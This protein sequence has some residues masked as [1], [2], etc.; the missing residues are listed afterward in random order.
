MLAAAYHGALALTVVASIGLAVLLATTGRGVAGG[1]A[2]AV[3]VALVAVWVIGLETTPVLLAVA[4]LGGAAFLRFALTFGGWPQR[5]TVTTGTLLGAG[6]ASAAGLAA[7][8][9]T[10]LDGDIAAYR[11]GPGGWLVIAVT[12]GLAGLGHG[13]LAVAWHRA[14]GLRRRQL[15]AVLLSGLWGLGSLSSLVLPTLGLPPAPVTVPLLPLYTVGLVYGILRYRLMEVNVWAR[16][17]LAWGL[18]MAA[19]G[20]LVGVVAVVPPPLIDEAP[21]LT[22]VLAAVVALALGE[23]AR[24]LADRLVYPGAAITPHPLVLWRRQLAA[25]VDRPAR[26]LRGA[27]ELGR[28]LGLAVAVTWEHAA[29]GPALVLERDGG[30]AW[31]CRLTGWDEAP[32]GPLLVAHSFAATLAEAA[33]RLDLALSLAARE[34]ERQQQERLAELGALAATVAHDLRNPLNIVAMAVA[35]ADPAIRREVAE[36]IGRMDWLVRDLLDYARPWDI[37]ARRLDLA[38][39]LAAAAS[40]LPGLHLEASPPPGLS[41]HAD[42]RRLRQVLVNLLHNAG[43]ATVAVSAE[44]SGD[45]AV[46][47]HVCDRGPGI[48]EDIRD[49]LFQPFVSRRP[50][51]TGLGLAIVA[52]VMAAHG[53]DVSLTPRPGWTTCITLRFPS[54]GVPA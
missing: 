40:G 19:A 8:M 6:A 7:G 20:V 3:F 49:R 36:Q 35:G 18:V 42:P 53:G 48:P 39:E 44:T 41:V 9:G 43:D 38:D 17:A 46:L 13:L 45:G 12:L 14:Q 51:G 23:P 24:R 33:G 31:I 16:R 26:A 32:P 11:P 25:A 28:R 47:V 4:P 27:A 21:G 29:A 5:Q 15:A 52:Q 37:A 50:G 54:P 10:L 2:L 34:R 30:T 22:A 1:R